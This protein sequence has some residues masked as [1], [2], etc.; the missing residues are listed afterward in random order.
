MP[1]F[2]RRFVSLLVS[3]TKSHYLC[4]F[5]TVLVYVL[6]GS[7]VEEN[8]IKYEKLYIWICQGKYGT[9]ES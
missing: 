2:V 7:D 9:A 5:G 1:D 8:I 6:Y 3:K 4:V